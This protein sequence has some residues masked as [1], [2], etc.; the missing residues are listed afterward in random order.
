[1]SNIP[2]IPRLKTLLNSLKFLRDPMTV[3]QRNITEY[4]H[5]Y[6]FYIGGIIPATFTADPAFIQHILQKNHRIYKKSP[7]HFEHLGHYVG[8]GLLTIDGEHWLRQRRLIQPSFHRARLAN[9]TQLMN[10]VIVERLARFDTEIQAGPVNVAEHMMDMAFSII[11]RSIFSVSVPEE[12]V[13]RMS[14]QI[15]QIQAFVI[16]LIRQPYLNGWRKFNGQIRKHEQL[17]AD[18]EHAILQLVQQRQASGETRDD[19]LQMLLDS[20]Y[21]DTGEAM[22][23]QQLLDELKIL[24]VAGHETSANGLAWTWYLL[25]Q[26]PEVLEKIRSE[27]QTQVGADPITF[28]DLPKLV[29]LSQVVD[30]ILRLYPPAWITDRMAVEADEFQGIKIAKGAIVATYIY[31]AHHSPEHWKEPEAFRPERFAKDAKITP[32]AYLPFGGGPRLCIGNHF[33]LM[34]MQLVIAEMARRY[35]FSLE[36]GHEIVPQPLITLRPKDGIWLRFWKRT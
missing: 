24:F 28:A 18:L 29:Y 32:F 11:M 36:P 26:H 10:A 7:I 27:L 15:T 30:E 3:I 4:G 1:M 14:A 22:N 23:E 25:S 8:K 13:Q 19:L 6:R 2:T 33:A 35:D 31:G 17:A 5:T 16:Q 20:R 12:Q 21:E 34:E 9:L